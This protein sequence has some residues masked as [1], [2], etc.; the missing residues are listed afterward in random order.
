MIIDNNLHGIKDDKVISFDSEGIP[1]S[2]YSHDEWRFW[3]L[4]F[5]VSFSRL[6]GEFKSVVKHLIYNS[7]SS[8][9]IRSKKSN[10]KMIIEGAI[11]FE[12]CIKSCGH[13]SYTCIDDDKIFRGILLAA[14]NK[15][16]KYKTWKNYLIFISTLY[17]EG[18]ISRD[19]G[20]AEK[21]S[22]YLSVKGDASTQALCIPE[23]IASV[24]YGSA[25]DVIEKYYHYR[26]DIS[27]CYEEYTTAYGKVRGR[28]K[29]NV[30]A[31][32]YAISQIEYVPQGLDIIFDYDGSWLSWLRGACYIVI[33][34]FTGCRDSE[35]K[36]FNIHSYQ[37]KKY[38]DMIIPVV[39]GYDTKPNVGGALRSTSWVTIPTVKKA[40][41]L[42]WHAFEFARDGW[43]E[44]AKLIKHADEKKLFN[45]KVESLFVTFPYM[46]GH[47]PDAGKQSIAHS[48]KSY[49]KSVNYRAK[50]ED[51]TEFNLLNPSR[52]GELKTGEIL[53]VHPH[54]FRRTFA[55][56]LVRN[57]LASLLDI[58]HQFKHMN[59]AMTSWYANQ[60]NIASYAD[61][62]VDRELQNEISGENKNYM[63]DVFCEIYNKAETL[64]GHEG[65]R[66][67][68]LRA[69]GDTSIYLSKEEIRRQVEDG[70]LSLVEHPGGYC[71]N[72]Y[73][74]RIC[75]MT[76]CQYKIVTKYKALKL[77]DIREK[78]IQKYQ[79]IESIGLDMPN[80]TSKLFYEI[81]SIEQVLSEHHI[82]YVVFDKKDNIY[83]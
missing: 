11:A 20:N 53:L 31:R 61:M 23:K 70:R 32:N 41:S 71:T 66:I 40:I 79:N 80:V 37:E 47:R 52:K 8:G 49:L 60:A 77:V 68:N 35:I 17:H 54:A 2:F 15:G 67:K 73:C 45:E 82:D 1:Y 55:V 29:N 10:A 64:S 48:L 56:Y 22:I 34:A 58:K 9:E 6:S 12:Q 18:I 14:K 38:A 69:E 72:P 78:L 62:L 57:K 3:N 24:Y 39:Y 25:L 50:D 44:K 75:D 28:S 46:R 74:D 7:I 43:R 59:I 19:I 33:A 81:R 21:L 16:Y 5:K 83:D 51:V 36:S 42:L 4:G 13:D 76:T 26:F 63:T 30:I 65:K 27:T